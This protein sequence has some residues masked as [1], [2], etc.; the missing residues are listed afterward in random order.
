MISFKRWKDI[1]KFFAARPEIKSFIY[2]ATD[3]D[4]RAKVDELRPDQF[5]C[6]VG[7]LPSIAGIGNNMDGMGHESPLFYYV[8]VPA[9]ANCS[10]EENDEAWETTLTGVKELENTLKENRDNLLWREFY[11]V[12]PDSV[13]I[14]PEFDMWGLMG[15]SIRFDMEHLD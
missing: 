5:P 2:G 8:M 9:G 11:Y 1:G 12:Q 3:E 14:D 4:I 6:L 10:E 15:W 13:H 7:I